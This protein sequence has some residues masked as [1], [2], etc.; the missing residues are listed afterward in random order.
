MRKFLLLFFVVYS[1]AGYGQNYI[2]VIK[3]NVNIRFAASSSSNLITQAK[4]GNIF[5]MTDE[6]DGWYAINMFSG[7]YR[8]I[9]KS[10]CKKVDYVLEIPESEQLRKT[11]FLAIL[12]AEDKAQVDADKKYP[13]NI[14][15]NIDYSRILVDKYKLNAL[16]KFNIQPPVYSKLILEGVKKRWDR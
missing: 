14:Y 15:A 6:K 7:E 9:H 2:Q 12:N 11:I 1:L 13:N 5:E 10:L 16:N 4:N 8:Y 3:S